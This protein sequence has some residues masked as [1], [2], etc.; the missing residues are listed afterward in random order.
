MKI[1]IIIINFLFFLDNYAIES[2]AVA[3]LVARIHIQAGHLY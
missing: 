2:K 3:L 1:I